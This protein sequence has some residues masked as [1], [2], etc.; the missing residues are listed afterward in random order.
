MNQQVNVEFNMEE[1]C[2]RAE[3][4]FLKSSGISGEGEKYENLHRSA[5]ALRDEILESI[6]LRGAYRFYENCRLS[7]DGLSVRTGDGMEDVSLKCTAFQQLNPDAIE[8]VYVYGLT[9]GDFSLEDRSITD[10]LFCDFW[11]TA[12]VDAAREN[13]LA[14]IGKKHPVSDS[15][16]P[17]FYGMDPMEISKLSQLVDFTAIDMKI[18]E[19]SMLL[20]Q[21]SCCGI[22]FKVNDKYEKLNSACELCLGN[23]KTCSLCSMHE[24]G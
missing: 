11:G 16:G 7:A 17:G 3:E 9:T 23:I 19:S 12:F 2:S 20:P 4:L 1:C 22:L 24:K 8:G 18:N 6:E 21:K 13:L 10:Q 5:F 15:F 14:E